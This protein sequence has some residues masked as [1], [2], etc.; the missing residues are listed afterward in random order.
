M[1]MRMK[2]KMKTK[3]NNNHK[4]MMKMTKVLV[5][6]Q[7]MSSGQWSMELEKYQKYNKK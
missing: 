3:R 1:I 4:M 7:R 5:K 6:K 2:R